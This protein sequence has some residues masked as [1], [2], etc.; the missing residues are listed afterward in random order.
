MP[1][2]PELTEQAE[3]LGITV[4]S[5]W[6]K[7]DIEDAIADAVIDELGD[8]PVSVPLEVRVKS[9]GGVYRVPN[10]PTIPPD[11]WTVV[12]VHLATRLA[13]RGRVIVHGDDQL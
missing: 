13:E 12:G 11:R 4:P 5:S 3:A 10:G 8:E 7:A 1:T 6:T 2:K 9:V